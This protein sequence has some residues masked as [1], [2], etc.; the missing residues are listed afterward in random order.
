[1]LAI[2]EILEE[3]LSRDVAVRLLKIVNIVS[4][5]DSISQPQAPADPQVVMSDMDALEAFCL[6]GGILVIIVSSQSKVLWMIHLTIQPYTTNKHSLETRLEAASFVQQ[7]TRSDI[8]LQMFISY[9]IHSDFY[10][11]EADGSD[12]VD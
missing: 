8:T 4:R 11:F 7:L 5:L 2:L 10:L 3:K 12:A 6:V 9:V 1:M